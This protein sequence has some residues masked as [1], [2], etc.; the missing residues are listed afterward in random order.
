MDNTES[1]LAMQMQA[2]DMS[3]KD[4]VSMEGFSVFTMINGAGSC[5]TSRLIQCRYLGR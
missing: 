5:A 1:M 4:L 3:I 2:G